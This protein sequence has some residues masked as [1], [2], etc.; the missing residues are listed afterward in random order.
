MNQ[1]LFIRKNPLQPN[2]WENNTQLFSG[3]EWSGF[4]ANNEHICLT[5]TQWLV[6]W[7][8]FQEKLK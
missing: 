2:K 3:I 5:I 1:V 4:H 7:E 8:L 6:A